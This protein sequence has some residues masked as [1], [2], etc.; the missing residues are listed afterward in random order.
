[1][2]IEINQV[3]FS[4]HQTPVL[5]GISMVL[6][7]GRVHVVLGPNGSGKTTLALVIAGVLNPSRGSILADGYDPS[8]KGFD[9][10][11][12][13]LAFQF[14]EEQVFETTVEAEIGFGL[15]NFGLNRSESKKR[16]QWA[17][18]CVGLP[19][20]MLARSPDELSYG[21]VRKV[22]LA[23]VIA[24]R[25]RYLLLD[26]PLAGLDWKSR[27]SVIDSLASLKGE[28]VTPVVFTHEPDLSAEIADT[29]SVV[30]EGKLRAGPLP[31]REFYYEL[32]EPG[33][34]D[35]AC[36]PDIIRVIRGLERGG[37]RV[38]GFPVRER[39]ACE[40]IRDSLHQS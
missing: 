12:L 10:S 15:K 17:L 24:L 21:E 9:R 8:A 39:E 7:E 33:A 18:E 28:G 5:K 4:Y 23:S 40:A 36:L 19:P 22:A 2:P 32:P 38:G 35:D 31:V 13:Q 27:G 37:I 11:L 6:P 3:E 25:P 29:V 30:A 34:V 1:V 14:P 26:E 20:G 16:S